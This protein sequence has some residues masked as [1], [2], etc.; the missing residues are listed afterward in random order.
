MALSSPPVAAVYAPKL[1]SPTPL[2]PT[3]RPLQQV[4]RLVDQVSDGRL[5]GVLPSKR[6]WVDVRQHPFSVHLIA[7]DRVY[8]GFGDSV[9]R[10]GRHR[11]TGVRSQ[12]RHQLLMP[13]SNQVAQRRPQYTGGGGFFMNQN[14]LK[15]RVLVRPQGVKEVPNQVRQ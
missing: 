8:Q 2:V 1:S 15:R 13:R 4:P 14:L 6:G 9:H 7:L 3:N 12:Q 10:F 5:A 11:S